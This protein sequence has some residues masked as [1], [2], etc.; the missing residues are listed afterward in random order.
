M[1]NKPQISSDAL[2]NLETSVPDRSD[3]RLVEGQETFPI[4]LTQAMRD[5]RL[6]M[7][8]TQKDLANRLGVGQSCVSKLERVNPDRT[9]E[10]VLADLDALGEDFEVSMLLKGEN[11]PVV[12][13]K[14]GSMGE[15]TNS[16]MLKLEG[17]IEV[18]DRLGL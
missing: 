9:F 5:V 15:E 2:A 3:N 8:L 7:E 14:L 12:S 13:A 1:T 4:A 16:V 11:F 10:S 6:R 18:S 17:Q